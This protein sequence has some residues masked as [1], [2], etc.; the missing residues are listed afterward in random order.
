MGTDDF[1]DYCLKKAG[2][3]KD[4]PFGKDVTIIKVEKKIFAQFFTLKGIPSCTLNS[5]AI[6]SD[7]YRN[8]Y[9]NTIVRGYHCPPIQQPYFNT[10]PLNNSLPNEFIL[11][12]IDHSY[13]TVTEKLPKY[14]QRRLAEYGY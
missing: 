12:M 5:D 14:I 3:Y 1:I 2:A 9:P 11:E 13:K 10:F 4:F 8:L 7:F 6:T